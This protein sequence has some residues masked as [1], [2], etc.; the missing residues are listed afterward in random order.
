MRYK[1]YRIIET[2][3]VHDKNGFKVGQIIEGELF[4]NVEFSDA[5]NFRADVVIVKNSDFFF[6]YGNLEEVD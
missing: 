6:Y 5:K 3:E 1:K 4:K 2:A